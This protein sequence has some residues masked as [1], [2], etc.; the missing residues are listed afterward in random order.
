MDILKIP[1]IGAHELR[2][3]LTL[4]LQKLQKQNDGVVVTQRGKPAAVVL[5]IKKYLQ[6][7]AINEEL[8]D[9]LRE[10]A[11]KDYVLELM[12]AKNEILAGKGKSAKKIFREFKI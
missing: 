5:S 9:A 11:N 1:F 2:K 7:K 3:N 4:L 12:A 6:L 10:I 8:E